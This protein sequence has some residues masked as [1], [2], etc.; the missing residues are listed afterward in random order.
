LFA[1]KANAIQ[2]RHYEIARDDVRIELFHQ[3]QTFSTIAR[4]AYDFNER[5]TRQDLS[6]HL[7]DVG[8]IIDY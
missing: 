8:G 5:A 7:S 3:V 1:H 2:F 4:G 6:Y